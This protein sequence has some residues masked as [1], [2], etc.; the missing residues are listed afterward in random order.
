MDTGVEEYFPL[1]NGKHDG[2][3]GG[4]KLSLRFTSCISCSYPPLQP[5]RFPNTRTRGRRR[6]EVDEMREAR[7]G[8]IARTG[9]WLW[10]EHGQATTEY[11]IIVAALVLIAAAVALG[12][13]GLG[14]KLGQATS[15]LAAAVF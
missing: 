11:A 6:T 7:S 14:A 3:Y 2:V 15:D 12:I 1:R 4:E 5:A 10:A 13:T 9:R 8:R